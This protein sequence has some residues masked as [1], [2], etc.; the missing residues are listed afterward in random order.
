[1]THRFDVYRGRRAVPCRTQLGGGVSSV[2]ASLTAT[3]CEVTGNTANADGGGLRI[4]Y[5]ATAVLDACEVSF[6]T[7]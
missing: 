1:M 5:Q 3:S 6:N 7:G 2:D 4:S